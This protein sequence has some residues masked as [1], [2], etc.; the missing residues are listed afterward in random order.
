MDAVAGRYMGA[1]DYIIGT[2][3]MLGRLPAAIISA[4]KSKSYDKIS[5]GMVKFGLAKTGA[6]NFRGMDRS[7]LGRFLGDGVLMLPFSLGEH[8]INA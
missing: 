2:L 6:V 1:D 4:G 3:K 5:S 7:Q 8:T